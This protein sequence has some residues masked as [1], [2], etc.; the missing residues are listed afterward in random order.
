MK[1][2]LFV[3]TYIILVFCCTRTYWFDSSIPN[4]IGFNEDKS[5]GHTFMKRN[6]VRCNVAITIGYFY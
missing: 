4:E 1:R 3:P 2:V 6:Y 5:N